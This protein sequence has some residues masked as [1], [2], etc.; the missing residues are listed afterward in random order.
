MDNAS[1]M[2]EGLSLVAFGMGF[3][4][5]FLTLLVFATALMS[6]LVMSFAPT[7]VGQETSR[8]TSDGDKG[9]DNHDEVIAVISAAVKHY[10]QRHRR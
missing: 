4:F 2:Q 1:L 3:V 9:P 8:S 5:V 6:R 10:R 7:P